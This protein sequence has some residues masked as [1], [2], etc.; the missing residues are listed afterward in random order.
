MPS[1]ISDAAALALWQKMSSSLRLRPTKSEQQRAPIREPAPLGT[2]ASAGSAC[3]QSGWWRCTDG[4]SGEEITG[5]TLR[6]FHAGETVPQ[7]LP[8]PRATGWRRLVGYQDNVHSEMSS[9]WKLVER[10]KKRRNAPNA[11]LM[12]ATEPNLDGTS[13]KATRALTDVIAQH[14]AETVGARLLSGADCTASGWWKCLDED[15]IDGTRW[16]PI[17]AV[18]PVATKLIPLTVIDKIKGVPGYIRQPV[19]WQFIRPAT[20]EAMSIR[21]NSDS[22]PPEPDRVDLDVKKS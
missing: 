21:A 1:S 6:Y 22:F 3:P 9:E 18:L 19:V 14:M 16:F 4:S 20:S 10:R 17:G 5:S 12:S 11:L 8:N 13:E 7:A 2:V 15:A